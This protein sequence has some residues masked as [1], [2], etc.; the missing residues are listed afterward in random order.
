[1]GLWAI[2]KG[3]QPNYLEVL[4]NYKNAGQFGEYAV[5]Y[6]LENGK[7]KGHKAILKNIYVPYRQG[8]SEIDLVMVHEKGIFVFE[9]KNY[10][11]WIFGEDKE[12][13][14]TRIVKGKKHHFRNPILQNETHI[15]ALADFL[16]LPLE[17]F[18]SYVVFSQRSVLKSV[19]KSTQQTAVLKCGNMLKSLRKLLKRKKVILTQ[20]QVEQIAQK[21]QIECS[22]TFEKKKEHIEYVQQLRKKYTCPQ[23]GNV[24]VKR[25][26]K[27]GEFLGCKGYPNCTYTR[28]IDENSENDTI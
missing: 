7:L 6:A 2:L 21:L 23:C 5:E 11:G 10:K 26:G 19:P 25:T 24:L 8:D 1:M 14:W 17:Y 18:T 12:Y 13:E 27:Y 28:D 16:Q 22:E 15:K 3:E 9:S 4:L 20:Q